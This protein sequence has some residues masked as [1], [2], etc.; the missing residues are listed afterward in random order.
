[1]L[2]Y[3]KRALTAVSTAHPSRG[4]TVQKKAKLAA[5][6]EEVRQAE[7]EEKRLAA[8]V[9][10]LC[11]GREDTE[12]RTD[13]LAKLRK[14]EGDVDQVESELAKFAEFDPEEVEK[15]RGNTRG[16]KEATNRWIDNVFNVQSWA[17][18]TFGMERKDFQAQFGIPDELDY[19]E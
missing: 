5:L 13:T 1:M 11:V 17:S 15:T 14:L 6:Q 12:E 3:A 2:T 7:A 4:A 9:E 18:K 8:E 16:A 10:E 19:I